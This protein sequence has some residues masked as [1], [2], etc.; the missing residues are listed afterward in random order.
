MNLKI[1]TVVLTVLLI[2]SLVFAFYMQGEATMHEA[3]Y[4]EALIDAEKSAQRNEVEIERLQKALEE[5]EANR[6]VAEEALS[7]LQKRKK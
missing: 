5:S 7:E 6:K 3:K 4:E 1:T 2:G